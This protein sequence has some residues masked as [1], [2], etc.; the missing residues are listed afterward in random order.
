[1]GAFLALYLPQPLLPQLD[2]DL[3]TP[4]A[5]TG[6]VITS[7]LVGFALAGLLPDRNPHRTLRLAMWLTVASSLVAAVSPSIWVLIPARAGQGLGVG[8]MVAGGLADVPRR[9]APEL[10]G[11]VTGAMISGTAMGGLLGRLIGY[12]GLFV[13]WRG[14]FLI[15]ALGVLAVITLSLRSLPALSETRMRV[16]PET[17]RVPLSLLIG[18][19]GI[20]FVSVG[21]FDLLP[22]HLAAPPFHLPAVY[23]DL[24]YLVF[25]GATLFGLVAGRALDRFGPRLLILAVAGIGIVLLLVGLLP[26]LPA[27]ALAALASICGAVGLH[28]GHSAS[29]AA[30]GRAAVGRYLAAYYTGGAL[31]APLMAATYQRWGW[32]GVILPLAASWLGVAILAATRK[33]PDRAQG[34]REQLG[35]GP[36]GSLG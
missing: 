33:Q 25:L 14:A 28:V 20:L 3:G 1:M 23:A 27:A 29:A 30:Y 24:V 21:M 18:G 35:A 36:A 31:A 19:G 13:T 8:L 32:P 12:A 7:A 10:A 16:L 11:R 34:Q 6:L 4:P 15:G 17:G 2:R 22:Y 26:S 9:L 5:I